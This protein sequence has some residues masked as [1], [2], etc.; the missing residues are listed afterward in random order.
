[1]EE[2]APQDCAWRRRPQGT[3]ALLKRGLDEDVTCVLGILS[4][5]EPLGLG[6]HVVVM[7]I[8][9]RSTQLDSSASPC[10]TEGWSPG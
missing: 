2:T 4:H 9:L 6:K 5:R 10:G 7:D 1:M 8:W 3:Q